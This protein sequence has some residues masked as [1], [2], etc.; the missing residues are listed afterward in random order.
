LSLKLT[1]SLSKKEKN[2]YSIFFTSSLLVNIILKY[3]KTLLIKCNLKIYKVLEPSC[4]SGEILFGLNEFFSDLN[5]FAF[6]YNSA[7][8]NEIKDF[9]F[10][11]NFLNIK[12]QNFLSFFDKRGV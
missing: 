2:K 4:G 8:Y 12:N 5:I 10:K 9:I 3:L 11:N 7:I 1:K 6:E